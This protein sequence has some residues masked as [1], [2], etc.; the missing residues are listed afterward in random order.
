MEERVMRCHRLLLSCP[1][2]RSILD[3][4]RQPES[5]QSSS[6]FLRLHEERFILRQQRSVRVHLQGYLRRSVARNE[7]LIW[8][9]RGW[10]PHGNMAAQ[11]FCRFPNRNRTTT[12]TTS[13]IS[14]KVKLL[15]SIMLNWSLSSSPANLIVNNLGRVWNGSN[16]HF[17]RK[18]EEHERKQA[19]PRK[20]SIYTHREPK[21]KRHFGNE[22]TT[23]ARECLSFL[24]WW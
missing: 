12:T 8:L 1:V 18:R 6:V 7:V 14:N 5:Q 15:L 24:T 2:G 13:L 3:R 17:E 23:Q 22:T 4:N 19:S 16:H 11:K 20:S 10:G 21:C 9:A